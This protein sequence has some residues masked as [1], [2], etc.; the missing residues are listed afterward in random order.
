MRMLIK[1]DQLT[2]PIILG[3]VPVHFLPLS[4]EQDGGISR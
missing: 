1:Q 3:I 4:L 2:E